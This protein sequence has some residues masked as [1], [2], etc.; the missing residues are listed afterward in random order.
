LHEIKFVLGG[1]FIPAGLPLLFG[2]IQTKISKIVAVGGTKMKELKTW[3]G[4]S[5]FSYTGSVETGTKITFGRKHSLQ[6]VSAKNYRTLLKHFSRNTASIGTSRDN[7][8]KGSVGEWLQKN[9][10]KIAIA[11]YVGP[12]L[13]HE[14]YAEKI[15]KSDIIFN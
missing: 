12:I 10:A 1:K 2:E 9:V 7:A 8:P 14:G 3:A 5:K 6:F 13:I 4:R 11:S 15:D